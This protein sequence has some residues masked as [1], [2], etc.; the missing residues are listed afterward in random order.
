MTKYTY[1]PGWKTNLGKKFQ[2]KLI[3]IFIKKFK[4]KNDDFVWKKILLLEK[5]T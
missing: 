3:L 2:K 5:H 1:L 4:K